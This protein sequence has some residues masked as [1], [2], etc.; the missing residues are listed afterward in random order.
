MCSSVGRVL[1]L[2]APSHGFE[3]RKSHMIVYAYKSQLEKQKQGLE[4]QCHPWLSVTVT[5]VLACILAL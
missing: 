1:A 4:T 2:Y 5:C 3:L